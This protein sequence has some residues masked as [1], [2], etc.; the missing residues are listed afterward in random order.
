M[1]VC[2]MPRCH[3]ESRSD[4]EE[5]HTQQSLKQKKKKIKSHRREQADRRGGVSMFMTPHS[6]LDPVHAGTRTPRSEKRAPRTTHCRADLFKSQE[7]CLS[8]PYILLAETFWER[9]VLFSLFFFFFHLFAV[10]ICTYAPRPRACLKK[11][12]RGLIGWS[13]SVMWNYYYFLKSRNINS[14]PAFFLF[15]SVR[16]LPVC[17]RT[18]PPF[19]FPSFL[20]FFFSCHL[21]LTLYPLPPSD[22]SPTAKT[23]AEEDTRAAGRPRHHAS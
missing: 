11:T 12:A 13:E 15:L 1:P 14:L 2:Q 19:P 10:C 20:F 16:P 3:R 23:S 6:R 9:A 5:K 7:L 18:F 8:F 21:L 22:L 4:K 17:F